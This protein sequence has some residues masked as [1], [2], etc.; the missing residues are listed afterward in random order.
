MMLLDYTKVECIILGAIK[1][2]IPQK[3][4][5]YKAKEKNVWGGKKNTLQSRLFFRN[6]K[7]DGCHNTICYL[8]L[9]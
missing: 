3:L 4:T 1:F 9:T 8:D 7:L 6:M 2:E 5:K